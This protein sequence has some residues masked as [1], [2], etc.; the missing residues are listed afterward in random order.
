MSLCIC[1]YPTRYMEPEFIKAYRKQRQPLT[2]SDGLTYMKTPGHFLPSIEERLRSNKHIESSSVPDVHVSEIDQ[3]L[4]SEGIPGID[5]EVNNNS[6]QFGGEQNKDIGA[7]KHQLEHDSTLWL[8]VKYKAVP[9][10][11]TFPFTHRR[12]SD[13]ASMTLENLSEEQLGIK[14]HIPS[15]A[16]IA[17][18]KLTKCNPPS[19]IFY[20]RGVFIPNSH[21][22]DIHVD[23]HIIESDWVNR[24]QLEKLIPAATWV[25]IRDTLALE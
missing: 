18:R 3:L 15:Y 24:E 12:G 14:L 11:W 1:R 19:R 22:L 10:V 5:N 6:D 20:Y 7:K 9:S 8:I 17:Y 13:S 2:I 25:Q 21:E 23:S 4:A 16:P